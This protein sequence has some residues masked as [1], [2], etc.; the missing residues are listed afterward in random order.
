MSLAKTP[1]AANCHPEE[2]SSAPLNL[3][4]LHHCQII[5][6]Y[7]AWIVALGQVGAAYGA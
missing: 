1:A 6:G 7:I 4:G 3:L 5:I 2:D